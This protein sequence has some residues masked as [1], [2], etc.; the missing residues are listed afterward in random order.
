MLELCQMIKTLYMKF[1]KHYGSLS[2]KSRK[3]KK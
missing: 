3:P 2:L 1:A